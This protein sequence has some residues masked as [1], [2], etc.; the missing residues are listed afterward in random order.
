MSREN[1]NYD[2]ELTNIMV[3]LSPSEREDFKRSLP[4]DLRDY[5]ETE[6]FKLFKEA[7]YI[8]Q[9]KLYKAASANGKPRRAI[10]IMHN[11]LET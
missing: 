8:A 4:E 7:G 10:I 11:K 9:S 1:E 3:M 2:E 5:I 6:E